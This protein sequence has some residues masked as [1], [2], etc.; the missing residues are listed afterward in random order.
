[1]YCP[2]QAEKA[3]IKGEMSESCVSVVAG[4]PDSLV[5]N[6]I[7]QSFAH[8]ILDRVSDIMSISEIGPQEV[9]LIRSRCQIV[10]TSLQCH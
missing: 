4:T 3:K 7:V 6:A 2:R 9:C 8:I 10:C 5:L 1:M